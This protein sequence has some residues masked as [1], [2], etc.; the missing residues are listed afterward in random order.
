MANLYDYLEAGFKV[1][2]LYGQSKNGG[3]ECG[4]PECQAAYK[5]PRI[6]NWQHTPDWSDDQLEVME[7]SGQFKSGYGVIVNGYIVIDVDPRNGGSLEQVREFY[8][9]SEFIVSTGGG[10]WHIYFKA[11][12]NVALVT[13]LHDHKGIDFKSSGFVVGSDSLHSSGTQYET[14]KGNPCDITEAPE[15]LIKLLKK[16]EKYRAVTSLGVIDV[17]AEEVK[18]MISYINPDCDYETWISCGMAIHHTLNGV[19]FDVWDR[20]SKDGKKYPGFDKL[21]RHWHSFGKS[22]NP[23]T[24]GTLIHYA[25]LAGYEQSIEF[26]VTEE[27]S[28]G[29]YLIDL[30]RPPGLVGEIAKWINETARYKLENLAVAAALQAVG[31]IGGLKYIDDRDGMTSNLMTFCVAGSGTGKE[32]I[33][34]R[35]ADCMRAAGLTDAVHGAIKS[36]QEI[37][38]NLT[39]HQAA[40]YSIDELGIVLQKII[41]SRNASYLEGVIGVVMSAYSKADSFLPVSGDVKEALKVELKKEYAAC[42]KAIDENEDKNG[43]IAARLTQVERALKTISDGIE[44]PFLSMVGYT[45]PVTFNQLITFETATNGFISRAV[46]FDEPE[47]NPKPQKKISPKNM[48]ESLSCRLYQLF[49]MGSFDTFEGQRIENYSG[50]T[51]I[52]TTGEANDRLDEIIDEFWQMAEDAKDIGLEAIPRRGY[53]ICAKVSF[54]LSI[55]EGVRTMEH[56]EWAYA[57]AKADCNRKMRLAL[58]NINKDDAPADSIAVKVQDLLEASEDGETE[59]VICNRCRP[60]KKEEVKKVLAALVDKSLI[61][62]HETQHSR[63]KRKVIKYKI[64]SK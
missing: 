24:L 4:N 14:I 34:Q 10:G 38:R 58:S 39:R 42:Q 49:S 13:H 9:L 50:K 1:F 56:V 43:T 52:K 21:E 25:E 61:E 62:Q 6:S 19:G 45:T 47:T 7:E 27:F 18:E 26:E 33:Q 11:P 57:L 31:N 5:H 23:R 59:G 17:T 54:V 44:Q 22:A 40:F 2:G 63:N 64:R 37:I 16:P 15:S 28:G 53:E 55:P 8:D 29:D 30:K 48:P 51:P 20:W 41:N 46:M 60:H 3:C 12:E 36:E 35:F 32:H